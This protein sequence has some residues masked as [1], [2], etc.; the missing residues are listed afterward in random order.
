[1]ADN[2]GNCLRNIC[3]NKYPES[4]FIYLAESEKQKF[5]SCAYRPFCC[6]CADQCGINRNG[7]FR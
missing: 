5:E 7:L 3:R 1:M 2:S 4:K 6:H